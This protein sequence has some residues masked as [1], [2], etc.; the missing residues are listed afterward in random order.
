MKDVPLRV[1]IEHVIPE[2]DAGQFPAKACVGDDVVVRA[3]IHADSADTLAAIL[4][5]RS[6][7]E[8]EWQEV[9]MRQINAGL[10]LW[11][12]SFK[13]DRLGGHVFTLQAWVDRFATWRKALNK[14]ANAGQD[15]ASELLEGAQLV[16]E[17]T[18]RAR[19]KEADWMRGQAAYLASAREE[20][21]VRTKIALTSEL[22][23]A[24][25]RLQDRSRATHYR[26]VPL[27]VE[28][29]RARFG[30]W[31][32]FFPR[33]TSPD[34]RRSGT[35]QDA[36]TRLPD[37]AAMGF[38]VVYLPPV[39]PIGK[40]HR[41]GP[42]NNPIAGPDDPGSPWAI[43]GAAGGHTAVDPALGTLQDFD[44]FVA[45]AKQNGLEVA[46]DLALQCSP[47]H[48]WVKEHPEWFKHRP[49]GTIKYAEN[50]P[51]KY[52]DIYPLDFECEKW[53][54]LWREVRESVLFW[55]KRGVRV[56]RVDNPHTK[57]YRFWEWLIKEV[58]AQS[59]DVIFL[60]EAFTRPPVMQY[61]AK[62]GFSQS[63]SYFTWR[64]TKAELTEYLTQLGESPMRETMRPNF[65]ANTPDI[66][67]EYLQHGGRPAF[68][69]RLLAAATLG[70]NYG[71]Y[72][73][74]Y[75]LCENRAFPGTEDYVDSEKY[76]VRHWD[77]D[78]PGHIKG[79]ITLVNR[80]RRE[81]PALQT[82]LNMEFLHSS[83]DSVL[84]FVKATPDRSNIVIVVLTVDPHQTHETYVRV[85]VTAL[86]LPASY[87]VEDLL[88]G[89]RY[90]WQAESNYVRL[91]PNVQPAHIFRVTHA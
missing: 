58:Q 7:A 38:D 30:A 4:Q 42:N 59:P 41:K 43:G 19:G 68:M 33:S 83:S 20:Q 8:K 17:A 1:V 40:T 31:Y 25:S 60:A 18:R 5:Y 85:P 2:I 63:Y 82:H 26:Q 28:R 80:V 52:E 69:I 75:E 87:E 51:K 71:I 29:E 81:N 6:A 64:N 77:L 50:P 55:V 32:E 56:F 54:L 15:V 9:P 47:D 84:A 65:F 24:M 45:T 66:F 90:R 49:D 76:Q 78:R 14:K 12:G 10:D 16:R 44:R 57:P 88:S 21:S 74:P 79:L 36:E 22:E 23:E 39:H 70:S 89:A 86:G 13:V 53:Q 34:P 61:L 11:E 37:I 91:D 72:G 3:T 73:P 27:V 46:L 48:P 35:F 62:I 67:H